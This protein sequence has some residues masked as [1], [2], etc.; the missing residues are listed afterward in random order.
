MNNKA[1][2]WAA[3]GI[4]ALAATGLTEVMAQDAAPPGAGVSRHL[5][6]LFDDFTPSPT[7][8]TTVSGG[9]SV[10][11]GPYAMHGKWW[12]DQ[13]LDRDSAKFAV[14]MD[15]EV[16]DYAMTPSTVDTVAGRNAHV[17]HLSMQGAVSYD[18][19]DTSKCP[20]VKGATPVFVVSGSG[21]VT[22]NGGPPPFA[23]PSQ[24]TVCVLGG[25]NL[26]GAPNVAISNIT[27]QIGAP[28]Q[29]HFGANPIHGVVVKCGGQDHDCTAQE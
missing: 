6:G 7:A 21:I 14:D 2:R 24:M 15:M 5:S 28:A 12:L 9:V 27:L 25:P 4:V 3:C 26:P 22:V 1:W 16:S 19:A 23:N 10:G 13:D 29:N 11:G 20:T 8:S 17:H 18:P